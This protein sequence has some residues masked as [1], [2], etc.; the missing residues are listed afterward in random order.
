MVV[1][2][3]EIVVSEDPAGGDFGVGDKIVLTG[4]SDPL[5][6]G[7]YTI[8]AITGSGPTWTLEVEEVIG[9]AN[10]TGGSVY[11]DAYVEDTDW[12]VVDLDLG[13]VRLISGGAFGT[14]AD[15]RVIAVTAEVTDAEGLRRLYPN[16]V[17]KIEGDAI[18]VWS[19]AEDAD[20]TVR[21]CRISLRPASA[22]VQVD[23]YSN[24]VLT[25]SVLRQTGATHEFGEL[26]AIK[27]DNPSLS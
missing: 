2:D 16:E 11:D 17:N 1:A 10:S 26:T 3:K 23:N 21:R 13:L 24:M 9:G 5:N 12:E 19:R 20:R 8:A 25:G 6:S 15:V 14:A 22:T 18:I 7:T 27:G 4:T